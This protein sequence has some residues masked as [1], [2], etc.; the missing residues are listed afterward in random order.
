MA[1]FKKEICRHCGKPTGLVMRT[2]LG[3]GTFLC[4]ECTEIFSSLVEDSSLYKNWSY[5]DYLDY[6]EYR[7]ENKRKLEEFNDTYIFFDRI[8]IDE[9]KGQMYF[10][11]KGIKSIFDDKEPDVFDIGDML[12]FFRRDDVKSVE[13]HMLRSDKV[14]QDTTYLFAFRSRWYPYAFCDK[15]IKNAKNKAKTKYGLFKDT[16]EI[17]DDIEVTFMRECIDK[18]REEKDA[19]IVHQIGDS[20]TTDYPLEKVDEI[21]NKLHDI[22]KTGSIDL[23]LYNDYLKTAIP[24]MFLRRKVKKLYSL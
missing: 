19:V 14:I 3:D 16:L 22:K 9:E 6:C 11:K 13:E 18:I 4:D 10:S 21:L 20:K 2:K 1:L 17:E 23:E 24:N 5:Q 8:H 15:V 7:K 12:I